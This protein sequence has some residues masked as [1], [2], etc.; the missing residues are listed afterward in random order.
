MLLNSNNELASW[1]VFHK[2]IKGARLRIP[3]L[4]VVADT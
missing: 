2:L 3:V 1:V 4:N